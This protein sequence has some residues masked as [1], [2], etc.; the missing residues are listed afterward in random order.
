MSAP[1]PPGRSFT[2]PQKERE[3]RIGATAPDVDAWVS[4]NAGS[5]KTTILRNRVIR[6]LLASVAPDRILCLTFTRAAAAEMQGRIFAELAKWVMLDDATL[7]REIAGLASLDPEMHVVEPSL[8]KRARTLFARAIETPGGLKIQTIHAFAE[9]VLHLFPLEAGVP[10]GFSVLA[11]ADAGA[12]KLA[13]RQAAIEAAI[14]EQGSPLG[15]AFGEILAASGTDAFAEALDAAVGTLAGLAMRD[16]APPG[17]ERR[18]AVYRAAL[19]VRHG[20]TFARM[21]ADFAAEALSDDE[22]EAICATIETMKGVSEPQLRAAGGYRNIAAARAAGKPWIEAYLR[23][24]LT[25]D[26]KLRSRIFPAGA[27]KAMPGLTDRESECKAAASAFIER[28]N[29]FRTFTRSLALLAFAEFVLARFEAAKKAQNALD[30]NDLIAAL[31]RLLSSANPSW[32]MMKLD[33]SIE[34]V[35]VDEAQDTTREMWDIIRALT[36]EFHAG[37]GQSDKT[38]S[39][40]VVGDEKQSIFS[41]QGAD[42]AVFEESRLDFADR[43]AHDDPRGARIRTPVPLNSSFRSSADILAAVDRVFED[44]ARCEGLTASGAPPEHS[45]ARQRF[46]GLVELWPLEKALPKPEDPAQGEAPPPRAPPPFV[47]LA[48]RIADRIAGWLAS[49]ARHLV[50]GTPVRPG[51]ILILVQTR[52][53]FFT[54]VLRALKQR[55]VP[56]S[57]ADRLKLQDEAVVRDLL[58][59]AEAAMLAEDDLAL[60]TALKTPLFGLDDAALEALARNR[61][62]SLRAALR[63]DRNYAAISARLDALAALVHRVSPFDF[64]SRLLVEPAPADPAMSG[65]KALLARLGHDASDPLDAFLLEAQGFTRDNPASV[66]LF[67]LAQRQRETMIK[68]DLDQGGDRVRVMTTHGAKGLEARIVILGDTLRKPDRGNEEAAFILRDEAGEALLVWAGPKAHEAAPLGA[69]RADRRRTLLGEYRRLL[70]VGMTRAADRL[71]IG[72]FEDN[73]PKSGKGEKKQQEPLEATWYDLVEQGFEGWDGVVDVEESEPDGAIRRIRRRVT[74][75]PV[76]PPA[77]TPPG[78]PA[79]AGGLPAWLTTPLAP[80]DLPLPPLRPSRGGVPAPAIPDA[81][82]DSDADFRRR[83]GILMHQLFEWLPRIEQE[84]R[85]DAGLALLPRLAPGMPGEDA[86]KLVSE[87]VAHIANPG[88]ARFFGSCAR[89]EVAVAGEVTLPD[90]SRRPVAGRIDRLVVTPTRVE[91]LDLKTGRP[92]PASGDKSITRQMALYAA[93]MGALYPGREIV[94]AV[95]WTETGALD[96]LDPAALQEALAAITRE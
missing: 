26:L 13:A 72:G 78:A 29:A 68:R 27:L 20:E 35:L 42:P 7:S 46:P 66:R 9:R 11:E 43:R 94:C 77:E 14:S 51:D 56:V 40:F 23:I 64:F 59:V 61:P 16:E 39:I 74:T 62:G 65:R 45:A 17:P 18:E 89:A 82:P 67:T 44:E 36:G 28:R 87:V 92:R 31:R 41:F 55:R 24:F 83:R 30:F 4:A 73:R 75:E 32:I 54:A 15:H 21:E 57:G 79:G 60:A 47:R 53:A 5:G 38:R 70:Y 76:A 90:G 37:E 25:K 58:V 19:N 22:I 33:A 6:L 52:N 34:H 80:D 50:D 2:L 71:Y 85:L 3:D 96:P 91:I 1:A 12:M 84:K 48:E 88:L 95:L 86:V 93:L 81:E 49:G 69:A 10:L 63:A 8:L